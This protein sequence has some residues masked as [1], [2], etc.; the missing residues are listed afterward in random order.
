MASLVYLMCLGQH[1]HTDQFY[2]KIPIRPPGAMVIGLKIEIFDILA[3]L[4][5]NSYHETLYS[6][7]DQ[8]GRY[9]KIFSMYELIT[10]S[11]KPFNNTK[12]R[13]KK[14]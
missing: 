10:S 11:C 6:F 4:T 5:Q 8:I 14:T 9:S 12:N 1:L 7:S 13:I 2:N 3:Y